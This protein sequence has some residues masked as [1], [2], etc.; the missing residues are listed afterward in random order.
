METRR[1]Q[2]ASAC[3]NLLGWD[4]MEIRGEGQNIR[5]VQMVPV[6]DLLGNEKSNQARWYT[7]LSQNA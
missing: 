5:T 7:A 1:C 6:G 4:A 2:A 3:H